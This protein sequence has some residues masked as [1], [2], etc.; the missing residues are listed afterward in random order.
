MQ[1]PC[2]RCK[3]SG[4]I[5]WDVGVT[6]GFVM[7]NSDKPCPECAEKGY[8]VTGVSLADLRGLLGDA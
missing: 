3:G 2:D 5:A 7:G 6:G 4:R 8:V 1:M